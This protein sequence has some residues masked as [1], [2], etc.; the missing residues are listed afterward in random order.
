MACAV[1]SQQHFV[2][3]FHADARVHLRKDK[4]AK[5]AH[6]Q[7]L[8]ALQAAFSN[9]HVDRGITHKYGS[10]EFLSKHFHSPFLIFCERCCKKSFLD[11]I[12]H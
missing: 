6:C 7:V 3:I 8:S 10:V 4:S 9:G 12:T 11:G 2:L 5:A 1:V